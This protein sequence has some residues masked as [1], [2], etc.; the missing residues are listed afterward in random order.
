MTNGAILLLASLED[1]FKIKNFQR[2][3]EVSKEFWAKEEYVEVGI[4]QR[5]HKPGH[6]NFSQMKKNEPEVVVDSN[7]KKFGK[8]IGL[9]DR[10]TGEFQTTI[11]FIYLFFFV[12]ILALIILEIN[13]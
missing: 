8:I 7:L 1:Y 9:V 2:G 10:H 13:K 4:P 5:V 6:N 12:V 11:A 3:E